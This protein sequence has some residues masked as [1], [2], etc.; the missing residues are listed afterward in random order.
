MTPK[1]ADLEATDLIE[2]STIESGSYVTRSI[3]GQEL[4][5]AIP[6]P[7]SGLTI[8]T[9]AIASGTIGRVL[10]Q[11]TGNVL[12]QS[13]SLAY[14]DSTKAFSIVANQNATTSL[15]LSNNSTGSSSLI[16]STLISD[17]AVGNSLLY[18]SGRVNN[19]VNQYQTGASYIIDY[20]GP[21]SLNL[22][23]TFAS[24]SN[25]GIRFWTASSTSNGVE[26]M[27]IASTGNV[28]INTTTDAGFRL[29]VNGTARVQNDL[30]VSRNQNNPTKIAVSNTTAGNNS[31]VE[32]GYASDSS[33]GECKI[34]KYSST[35]SA[36]KIITAS[37]A[38]LYN[39]TIA[40]DIAIL[41]DFATGKIK[42]AAGGSSTAQ[43]TIDSAGNVGI[44]TSTPTNTFELASTSTSPL[45]L[46]TTQSYFRATFANSGNSGI[47][48]FVSSVFS[49]PTNDVVFGASS[50]AGGR[51]YIKG[52]AATSATVAFLVQ[53]SAST[54]LLR[55][56]N[57]GAVGVNTS[58]NAGFK[59]D[60]NG[61]AIVRGVHEI[62]N[63][64]GLRLRATG[65]GASTSFRSSGNSAEIRTNDASVACMFF[66]QNGVVGFSQPVA[67]GN[68]VV[69]AASALL[70]IDSTTK[71]FLPPRMTTTERNAIASPAAGLIVY[72]TTLNLPHFFN[73]TIWVSL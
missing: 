46:A 16:T 71:G 45:R 27:R 59:L 44:G 25:S 3:T 55:I 29:D 42:F 53:N 73:G 56:W 66:N 10:F 15:T 49:F 21:V 32:G 51:V 1:G 5:D 22:S 24:G 37:N 67:F 17:T 8:G 35:T 72:D 43:M 23:S 28:L 36:Y 9:T 14:D 38:Y 60:V 61:T 47:L 58:T 18:G 70:Q 62:Q 30:S 11:G 31:F 65:G 6:L 54:D 69:S 39:G 52:A 63:N 12:Q 13:S 2:V 19:N 68:T 34:G 57:D 64:S 50:S 20:Q 40:G 41:N 33:S 4:I 48:D 26:R 7:P